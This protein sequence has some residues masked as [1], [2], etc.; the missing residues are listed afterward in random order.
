MCAGKAPRLVLRRDVDRCR[1]RRC[2]ALY[3]GLGLG[4]GEALLAVLEGERQQLALELLRVGRSDGVIALAEG[5]SEQFSTSD[6]LLSGQNAGNSR[7]SGRCQLGYAILTTRTDSL[8]D[9]IPCAIEQRRFSAEQ[10]T[11]SAEHG[12]LIRCRSP[13]TAAGLGNPERSH[14][15]WAHLSAIIWTTVQ[16]AS[17]QRT[18]PYCGWARTLP[19]S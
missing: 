6:S 4:G 19:G 18:S 11:N 3:L 10:T 9:R 5:A 12:Y 2:R 7:L 15:E 1:C 8:Y 13:P 17:G 16:L 14:P